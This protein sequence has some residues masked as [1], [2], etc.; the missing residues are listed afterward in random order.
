MNAPAPV[1]WAISPH[2]GRPHAFDPP[3]LDGFADRGYAEAV[4]GHDVNVGCPIEVNTPSGA[5]CAHTMPGEHLRI[6]EAPT[7]ALC[8]ACAM[9]AAAA[10]PDPPADLGG[11]GGPPCAPAG[12]GRPLPPSAP[13]GGR[14]PPR[15]RQTSQLRPRHRDAPNRSRASFSSCTAQV[16]AVRVGESEKVLSSWSPNDWRSLASTPLGRSSDRAAAA[17]ATHSCRGLHRAGRHLTLRWQIAEN[18]RAARAAR[19]QLHHVQVLVGGVKVQSMTFT[20]DHL[21]DAERTVRRPCCRHPPGWA[22]RRTSAIATSARPRGI[23]VYL[24]H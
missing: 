23:R 10:L 21:G 6:T 15:G 13:G 7:G 18:D 22:Q 11:W 2:D 1:R 4:C 12:A 9:G 3:Q 14:S 8:L 19:R 17:S 5:I 20:P 24:S 16:F